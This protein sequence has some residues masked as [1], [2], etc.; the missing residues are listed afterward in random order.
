MLTPLFFNHHAAVIFSKVSKYTSKISAQPAAWCFS[1]PKKLVINETTNPWQVLYFR[2]YLAYPVPESARQ[3]LESTDWESYGLSLGRDPLD[4]DGHIALKC[5]TL[6]PSVKIVIA[7]HCYWKQYPPYIF[8]PS[9][10]ESHYF[11]TSKAT[12]AP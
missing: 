6:P 12:L 7:I 2:D 9:S 4:E 5:E 11:F 8:L 3:A 10:W 1:P